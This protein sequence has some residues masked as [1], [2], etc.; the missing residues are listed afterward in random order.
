MST[1]FISYRQTDEQQRQRV[2]AF[3]ERLRNG[4]VD[5]VLDQFLLDGKPEGPDEGWDKWSSDR[6]LQ[7]EY[8]LVVGTR[9][10]FQCFDKT[11]PPGTGL[12]AACE[13]D[14]LRERIYESSGINAS[15]R[16]VLF[17]EAEAAHIPGKLRRYHRFDAERDFA[18]IARWLGGRT[19][20]APAVTA[21]APHTATPHNLPSLQPFFGRKDELQKIS[22]ALDPESR[23]WGAIIDG[24]GGMGKTSLAVRAAYDAS[25]EDFS[26]IAFVSLKSRELDDDG[27]RDLSSFLISG[28][29]E[30]FNELAREL[31]HAGIAKEPEGQR[32]RLLLEALRDSRTLLVLDNLESLTKLERDTVFSLVKR[33]PTGCKAILTSRVRIG[34]GAEELILE[35]LT[36]AAAL[37]TLAKLA[38]SNPGLARTSEA[39]RLVLYRETA[40]KPLLLRWTA[41][42][43]GRGSCVTFDDAISYLR[44][45]PDE[46]DPLEFVFGDLVDGFSADETRVLCALTYF[47]L[48]AT[49]VHVAEIAGCEAVAAE[50]ALRSLIN[51]SLVV[52]S[53]ELKTFVLVPLVSSFLRKKRPADMVETGN[54]L[55]ARAYALIVEN[56]FQRYDRFPNLEAAWPAVA[57]ALP[58]FIAGPRGKLRTVCNGLSEFLD[59][60]GHWDEQ[61]ALLRDAESRAAAA[62]ALVDAG[63]YAHD[64]G[65]VHFMREQSKLVLECANRAEAY[66]RQAAAGTREQAVAVQ[67]RG[68]GHELA[69][70]H[71]EAVVA[72]REA[73][74]LDRSLGRD[75]MDVAIDLN[76]L[77]SAQS[78]LG[79]LE[80]A[81]QSSREALRIA[82]AWNDR[83][84]IAICAGNLAGIVMAR[85]DW[86]SAEPLAQEALALAQKVGRFELIANS[87][88]TLAQVLIAQDKKPEAL[89][90]ARRAVELYERLGSPEVS[91][92]R[93]TL[94]DCEDDGAMEPPPSPI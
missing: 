1:V 19:P 74:E 88:H 54:R 48:P 92:A 15:I 59:F 80:A 82:R 44:S 90:H 3:A 39:E 36:E 12:G 81:Q 89:E 7:S 49:V 26:R 73:L 67:L 18:N 17:D 42:Q 55:E 91:D 76:D 2:R 69:N 87:S 33:L 66:W 85:E 79:D 9:A 46:N 72:F 16:V 53:E 75:S 58:G 6:A 29:A 25:P 86:L 77:S 10:W 71:A 63:W 4:G 13:A 24:A 60:N 35:K 5:V 50:R 62:G 31:G 40:G 20:G 37:E 38:E 43:L 61:L 57:A 23:T 64:V 56:G 83:E 68:H 8:V 30:M 94:A 11:Q 21:S 28:L 45:C 52:P 32:P 22:E 34:S 47:T 84:H 14:D 70:N 27:V 51:R 41:G 93:N 65:W 78:A